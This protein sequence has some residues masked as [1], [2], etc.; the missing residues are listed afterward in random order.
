MNPVPLTWRL[1]TAEELTKVYLDEMRRDF[2]QSELKPLSMILNSEAAG[3][4]HTWG[5]YDGDALAAYLLMVRP[6]G[7]AMSQLDYFAVLPRYRASGLGAAL[8]A[9]LPPQAARDRAMTPAMARLNCFFIVV[10][11]FFFLFLLIAQTIRSVAQS[12]CA[13]ALQYLGYKIFVLVS[14]YIFDGVWDNFL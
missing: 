1:L 6:V 13:S 9:E 11:S 3:T 10:F 8:L 12:C 4:A 5:I 2:P 14:M 7:C